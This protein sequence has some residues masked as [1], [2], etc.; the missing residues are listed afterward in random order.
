MECYLTD[1]LIELFYRE[2]RNSLFTPGFKPGLADRFLTVITYEEL[3]TKLLLE[4][5][6]R[7]VFV[8]ALIDRQIA[9]TKDL[10]WKYKSY[11]VNAIKWRTQNPGGQGGLLTSS[12]NPIYAAPQEWYGEYFTADVK[13][14]DEIVKAHQQ[15]LA[16]QAEL[17][18]RR[19]LDWNI[20]VDPS[21]KPKSPAPK[22][23]VAE[24]E[25]VDEGSSLNEE[26]EE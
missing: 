5:V 11:H 1:E 21:V 15:R 23:P 17:E 18:S 19:L 6:D 12:I 7:Y 8:P 9:V 20:E 25:D 10:L 22:E 2:V 3:V 4:K 24:E 13:V 16:Q 14:S 26:D